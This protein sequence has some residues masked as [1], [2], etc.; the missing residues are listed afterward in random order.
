MMPRTLDDIILKEQKTFGYMNRNFVIMLF[1]LFFNNFIKENLIIYTSLY[2]LLIFKKNGNVNLSKNDENNIGSIQIICLFISTEIFLQLISIFFIMPFYKINL[3]FKKNLIIFMVASLAL[4]IPLPILTTQA[5]AYI[6][7]ASIDIMIHK[8]I[9]FTC[10]CYLVYLIPPQWKYAHIRASSL[11][12]YIM[13]IGKFSSCF[14]CFLCFKIEDDII[15]RFNII[16]LIAICFLAYG[17]IGLIIYKSTN[18][19][20]KALARVL[21]KKATE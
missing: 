17:I 15:Q 8:I 20:V 11:P 14:L 19:R 16:I 5:G 1:L 9:E 10:S 12:I 7:I 3:I 18:F 13:T 6:P 21:R 4:M 2:I